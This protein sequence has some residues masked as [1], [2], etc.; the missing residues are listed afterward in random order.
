MAAIIK[1]LSDFEADIKDLQRKKA[2]VPV[3]LVTYK[4]GSAKEMSVAEFKELSE[5]QCSNCDSTRIVSGDNLKE[6]DEYIDMTMKMLADII[7][8]PIP[9]RNIED[10]E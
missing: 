2:F 9:N 1:R 5:E 10:Y 8:N 6:F 3:L 7:N 4:D